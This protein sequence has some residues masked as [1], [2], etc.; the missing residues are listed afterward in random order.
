M[1]LTPKLVSQT[2]RL[3]VIHEDRDRALLGNLPPESGQSSRVGCKNACEVAT[4]NSDGIVG[5]SF[6]CL[7]AELDTLAR[8]SCSSTRNNRHSLQTGFIESAAGSL[9]NRSALGMR[10]VYRLSIRTCQ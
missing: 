8:A 4:D 9:D 10:K 2:T 7:L 1:K 6:S 5:A 3:T